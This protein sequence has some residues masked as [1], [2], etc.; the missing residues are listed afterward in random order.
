MVNQPFHKI[1]Q[2][3]IQLTDETINQQSLSS[4]DIRRLLRFLSKVVSILEQSFQEVLMVMIEL[5]YLN[6]ND[7]KTNKFTQLSIELDQLNARSRYRD[8]EEICSRLHH[9]TT[10]Y[11][12]NIESVT[13]NLPNFYEWQHILNNLNDQEG[14][15]II[16]VNRSISELQNLMYEKDIRKISTIA[17][18][19]VEEIRESLSQ[20]HS[21]N[22][23]ILG[24]SGNEGLLEIT[25][26][27]NDVKPINVELILGDTYKVNGQIGAFGPYSNAHDISFN[28]EK[29][30]FTTSID[31][32]KLP[33][34]LEILRQEMKKQSITVE[35]D[36]AI[37]EIA[38]A[39]KAA[40]SKDFSK[41]FTFLKSAGK[42]A[43]DIATQIGVTVATEA[44]K[45]A[46]NK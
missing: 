4:F 42:W 7:L 40:K 41:V 21:L 18:V 35:H 39:E 6:K 3:I 1:V 27:Q 12:S 10:Y 8:A 14:F 30:S 13:R 9:L 19:R 28:Q 36:I 11:S 16:L 34:E 43:L 23:Q 25:E 24:L 15:I 31:F 22:S 20:L 46:I 26:N 32:E 33:S 29:S 5:K 2:E 38:K 45:Q 44:L 17:P 37:N